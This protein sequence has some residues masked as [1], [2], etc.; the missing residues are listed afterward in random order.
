MPV[1]R[2][3][4]VRRRPWAAARRM[5]CCKVFARRRGWCGRPGMEWFR[6]VRGRKGWRGTVYGAPPS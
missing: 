5:G 3:R 2:F 6:R 4:A 1:W